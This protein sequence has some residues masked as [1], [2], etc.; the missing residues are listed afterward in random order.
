MKRGVAALAIFGLLALGAAGARG[1]EVWTRFVD[2]SLGFS[3]GYPADWKVVTS[4]QG[5]LGVAIIGPEIPGTSG[6]RPN[7]NIVSEVLPQAATIDQI[8]ALAESQV[9]LILNSYQRLRNDRTTIAGRPAILRYFTWKRNDGLLIYQMQLFTFAG[10]R[11]F[12][13]TGTTL[14]TSPTLE[15]VVGLLQRIL[16]TFRPAV[17]PRR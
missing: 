5:P 10:R 15:R 6:F 3:L 8:E 4:R 17:S 7:V 9:A 13:V 12:V 16:L 2:P 14:A 1:A 11:A